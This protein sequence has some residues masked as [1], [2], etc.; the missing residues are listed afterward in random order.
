MEARRADGWEYITL[1]YL[2][3]TLGAT[4]KVAQNGVL[5]ARQDA[6]DDELIAK[7]GTRA[8]YRFV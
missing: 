1:E 3:S 8:V 2:Y 4:S 6:M 7:S 5:F